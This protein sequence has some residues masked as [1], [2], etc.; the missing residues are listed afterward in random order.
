[1]LKLFCNKCEKPL[2]YDVKRWGNL[3]LVPKYSSVLLMNT[4]HDMPGMATDRSIM[5]NDLMKADCI[6]LCNKCTMDVNDWINGDSKTLVTKPGFQD[7]GNKVGLKEKTYS[8][9]KQ[10]R[11]LELVREELRRIRADMV[12][13]N[14]SKKDAAGFTLEHQLKDLIGALA[15]RPYPTERFGDIEVG[16]KQITEDATALLDNFRKLPIHVNYWRWKRIPAN[17]T[18]DTRTWKRCGDGGTGKVRSFLRMSEAKRDLNKNRNGRFSS[19]H[20]AFMMRTYRPGQEILD[21]IPCK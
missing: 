9:A 3:T 8:H 16:F 14:Y 19:K 7:I 5:V 6:R 15:Q 17:L 20:C 10:Y 12:E 13:G 1:M 2:E 11:E 18:H 21:T 4:N